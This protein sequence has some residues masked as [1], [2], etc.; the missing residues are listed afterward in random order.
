MGAIGQSHRYRA[1]SN[2]PV[3]PAPIVIVGVVASWIVV[4]FPGP[5]LAYVGLES[6]SQL[7]GI[8]QNRLYRRHA[9]ISFL[10]KLTADFAVGA[11]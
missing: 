10:G 7:P 5:G 3:S 8:K 4:V 9:S 11:F 2:Y 6:E 1:P